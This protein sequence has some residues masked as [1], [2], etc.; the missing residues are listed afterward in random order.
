GGAVDDG[1]PLLLQQGDEPLLGADVAAD[2]VVDVVEVAD[3][4]ALFGEGWEGDVTISD[5]LAVEI[6]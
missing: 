5:D 2:A 6:T 1:L 4:G 3:D